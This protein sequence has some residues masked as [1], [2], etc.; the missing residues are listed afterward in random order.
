MSA[1]SWAHTRRPEIDE[2]LAALAAVQALHP[3][4]TFS[5][6]D[7]AEECGCSKELIRR[8]REQGMRK[9]RRALVASLM[10]QG[11][12]PADVQGVPVRPNS[13]EEQRGGTPRGWKRAAK[14]E[15][16]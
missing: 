8:T 15:A 1:N 7:I 9:L 2:G 16:A 11:F 3:G 10:E 12:T 6:Q 4:W 5:D 14:E 13:G